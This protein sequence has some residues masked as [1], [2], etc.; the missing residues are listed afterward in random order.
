MSLLLSQGGSPPPTAPPISWAPRYPDRTLARASSV[1]ACAP[2]LFAVFALAQW[3]VPA[4]AWCAVYPD[5]V[6]AAEALHASRQQA[7]GHTIGF[8][9][10]PAVT[11][12]S[13]RATH[14][15]SATALERFQTA[16]H[17]FVAHDVGALS[18]LPVPP[19]SW[20]PQY[21]EPGNAVV[22]RSDR[23][24]SL[25]FV[26]PVAQ[27]IAPLSWAPVYPDLL[28][29]AQPATATQQATA[30]C[31]GALPNLPVPARSWDPIYP[32]HARGRGGLWPDRQQF[33]ALPPIQPPRPPAP[34]LSWAPMFSDLV[35][36]HAPR[37]AGM[38]AIVQV[39]LSPAPPAAPGATQLGGGYL[40][41]FPKERL[42]SLRREPIFAGL[43]DE[44]LAALVVLLA[45]EDE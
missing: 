16:A 27:A 26:A 37:F 21:P 19:L 43:S 42:Q 9:P 33:L 14:S 23:Q 25:A 36:G 2:Y 45:E 12:L 11:P 8:Q 6:P 20:R 38:V 34:E 17:Q 4:R 39:D 31:I 18:N 5:R 44:E 3:P 24:Q 35:V 41:R 13:W 22:H 28:P 30:A 29:G 40:F 1:S 32:A 7:V 15:D 10:S